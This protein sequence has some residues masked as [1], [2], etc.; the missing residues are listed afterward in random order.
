M[1]GGQVVTDCI[2]CKIANKEAKSKIVFEDET[3]IAFRDLSPKAPEHILIIPKKHIASMNNFE[4]SDKDVMAH[5]IV[6]VV[7]K[8]A[9]DLKIADSGYRVIINTGEDGGQTVN[10]LHVHLLGGRN[11]TWP[12][13]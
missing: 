12:P 6:E 8:I 10:H 1:R 11:M 2:F 5:I 9:T 3:V 7:P 4:E 13:G